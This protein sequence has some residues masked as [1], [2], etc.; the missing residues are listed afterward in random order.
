MADVPAAAEVT[1]PSPEEALDLSALE[2]YLRAR[3]PVTDGPLA[4]WRFAGGHA[5]LTYLAQSPHRLKNGQL[6]ERNVDTVLGL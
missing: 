5:N 6:E 1:A 3:L 4:V 2:P